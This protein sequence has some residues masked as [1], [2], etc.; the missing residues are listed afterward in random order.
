[1]FFNTTIVSITDP[2][3]KYTRLETRRASGASGTVYTAIDVATGAEVAIKQINLQ[4]QPK[5]ELIINEILV[6][7]ELQQP[8]IVNYVDR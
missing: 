4:K 7:K 8:N 1:M 3:K 5:K 2:K 6:M